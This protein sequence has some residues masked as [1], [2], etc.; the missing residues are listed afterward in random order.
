MTD[1]VT[2]YHLSGN[3]TLNIDLVEKSWDHRF[4]LYDYQN[5]FQFVKFLRRGS[6]CRDV[7]CDISNEQ[8]QEIIKR[9]QLVRTTGMSPV[10]GSWRKEGLS[11]WDM[12]RKPKKK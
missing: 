11:D 7:K 1:L 5:Q 6:G 12:R 9:L 4:V 2:E 3:C 10:I 8:A